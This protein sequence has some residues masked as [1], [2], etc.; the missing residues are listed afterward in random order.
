MFSGH[1][2][3]QAGVY[4]LLF[5]SFC[6]LPGIP[7]PNRAGS[8]NWE[9]GYDCVNGFSK[10]FHAGDRIRGSSLMATILPVLHAGQRQ[11]FTPVSLSNRSTLVSGGFC[12]LIILSM[13]GFSSGVN[14]KLR[15]RVTVWL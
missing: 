4:A 15:F 10:G 14:C 5:H 12:W 6:W 1:C 8:A 11:G 7:F 2:H 3:E 13:S 9:V